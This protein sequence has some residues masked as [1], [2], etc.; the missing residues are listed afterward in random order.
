M[1]QT[2]P[3]L[4]CRWTTRLPPELLDQFG[5]TDVHA[6]FFQPKDD[7]GGERTAI[8]VQI[9][10]ATFVELTH[11]LAA[12]D[13]LNARIVFVCDTAEQTNKIANFAATFLPRHRRVSYERAAEHGFG[14]TQ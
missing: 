6:A 13:E 8:C 9:P 7:P 10:E 11:S 14:P 4:E 5:A 3:H 2:T 1:S 12:A